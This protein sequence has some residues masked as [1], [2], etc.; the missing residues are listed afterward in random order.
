M[1]QTTTAAPPQCA[2]CEI[3]ITWKPIVVAG[4]A[5][6]CT[7]GVVGGPCTYDYSGVAQPETPAAPAAPAVPVAAAAVAAVAAVAAAA[8]PEATPPAAPEPPVA[9]A[10]EPG[11]APKAPPIAA[12][13]PAVD[14]APVPAPVPVPAGPIA[15]FQLAVA[16]VDGDDEA[17]RLTDKLRTIANGSVVLLRLDG[18]LATFEVETADRPGFVAFL[19]ALP[20]FRIVV[21]ADTPSRIEGRLDRQAVAETINLIASRFDSF[22]RLNEFV[23]EIRELGGVRDVRMRRLVQGV[24]HLAVDYEASLPLSSRLRELQH[25]RVRVGNQGPDGLEVFVTSTDDRVTAR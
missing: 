22:Q 24:L 25:F 23:S 13:A 20:D 7:G 12:P 19:A 21:E 18:S 11:P 16:G 9:P 4:V 6:G 5:F 10:P 3:A 8:P 1:T 2:T 15:A 17:R 14:P